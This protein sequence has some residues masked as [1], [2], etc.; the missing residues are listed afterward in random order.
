MLKALLNGDAVLCEGHGRRQ[1]GIRP[2]LQELTPRSGVTFRVER[3]SATH[4]RLIS[5]V[6]HQRRSGLH[7]GNGISNDLLIA[8]GHV[9]ISVL[10][11]TAVQ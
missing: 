9:W 7:T 6:V 1:D 2:V 4:D 5:V 8:V 10:A 11:G 3:A